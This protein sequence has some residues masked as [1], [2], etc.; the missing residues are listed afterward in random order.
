MLKIR[1]ILMAIALSFVTAPSL[2]GAVGSQLSEVDSNLPRLFFVAFS[3]VC[4]PVALGRV[5]LAEPSEA[6]SSFHLDRVDPAPTFL[7]GDFEPS[8]WFSPLSSEQRIF[9]SQRPGRQVCI[10]VLANTSQTSEVQSYFATAL[11][12]VGF[13]RVERDGPRQELGYNE[14]MWAQQAAD[15]YLIAL[16]QGPSGVMNGGVGVQAIARMMLVSNEQF[17]AALR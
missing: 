17:E 16:I 4:L 2:S 9:V 7:T 1:S 10:M 12:G 15:G 3:D 5:S 14:T 8:I 11:T 13:A 6:T